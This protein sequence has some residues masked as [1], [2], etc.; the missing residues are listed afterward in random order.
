MKLTFCAACGSADDLQ[1]HHLVTRAG[2]GNDETNLITLCCD[3]HLNLHK[4]GPVA[5]K[6]QGEKRGGPN[7][8]SIANREE[9]KARAEAIRPILN[10]LSDLSTRAIADEL[11]ARKIPT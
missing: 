2:G 7:A 3:C 6:A 1:H 5:A 9:A 4:A 10:E 11:K 8:R